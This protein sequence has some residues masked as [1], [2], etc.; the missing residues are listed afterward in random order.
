M[1]EF[2][3]KG[4][5]GSDEPDRY[6]RKMQ[7]I[8]RVVDPHAGPDAGG[9]EADR[10]RAARAGQQGRRKRADRPQQHAAGKVIAEMI[11]L[12]DQGDARAKD[13]CADARTEIGENNAALCS[14]PRA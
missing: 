5:S 10:E 8:R 13:D 11:H 7:D 6:E 12:A 14:K 2:Q 1:R 4:N 9:D 3:A